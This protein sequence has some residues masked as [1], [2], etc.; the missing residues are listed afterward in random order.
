[1]TVARIAAVDAALTLIE[2]LVSGAVIV[3][4]VVAWLCI[5][6]VRVIASLPGAIVAVRGRPKRLPM[7]AFD[8]GETA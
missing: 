7:V 1:M 3:L 6:F 4:F 5:A 2:T 8:S